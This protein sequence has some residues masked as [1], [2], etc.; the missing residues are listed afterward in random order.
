MMIT[1]K[2]NN[3]VDTKES[4]EWYF[5]KSFVASST[6][7]AKYEHKKTGKSIFKYWQDETGYDCTGQEFT[8]WY[9]LF[10]RRGHWYAYH[11]VSRDV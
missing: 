9:R 4:V 5:G 3:A 2:T 1:Y 8:S 11:M 10:Q 6:A 7:S